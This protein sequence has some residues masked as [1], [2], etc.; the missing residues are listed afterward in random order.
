MS[1][2]TSLLKF[3]DAIDAYLH[4]QQQFGRINSRNSELRYR[5]VLKRHWEDVG[6]RSPL[7]TDREHV[8]RTLE[9]WGGHSRYNAH[10][11]LISFYD[12]LLQEGLRKDNPARQVRRTKRRTPSVYR[13][14]RGEATALM[15][16]C[17]TVRER[18]LIFIGLLTGARV[19]ELAQLQARH[20]ERPGWVWFSTDIAKGQ[21]ERWVPVLRELEPIIVDLGQQLP[22]GA[23]VIPTRQR[24]MPPQPATRTTLSRLVAKV[25][26]RAGIVA[27]IHPHLLR[28]SFGD[29]IAKYAGLQVAK[30]LMGHESVETTARVYV[31]H[32]V[33]DELAGSVRGFRYRGAPDKATPAP[34]PGPPIAPPPGLVARRPKHS[35]RHTPGPAPAA[36]WWT[37]SPAT[38]LYA[39]K[40]GIDVRAE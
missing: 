38:A 10:A 33:L 12:W 35:P 34:P 31:D 28:H 40:L 37:T 36:P 7:R 24:G 27:P 16:A 2:T 5:S 8:K 29:H 9:R 26:R 18:R 19:S 15:D 17:E 3:C 13:L 11:I 23:Y 30:T 14:T 20:F 1:A 39:Q 4:D 25:G 21:R 32:P 22:S 6:R